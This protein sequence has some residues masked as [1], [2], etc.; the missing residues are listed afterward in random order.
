MLPFLQYELL[1]MPLEDQLKWLRQA[2]FTGV[3]CFWQG[4]RLAI[5]GGFKK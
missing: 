1:L 4:E 5:F 2:G 3:N